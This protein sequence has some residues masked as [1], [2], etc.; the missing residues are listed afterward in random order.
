MSKIGMH[1][2]GWVFFSILKNLFQSAAKHR[3]ILA[4]YFREFCILFRSASFM[5]GIL[6]TA[7]ESR[8]S[9]HLLWTWVYFTRKL[10]NR[11][12]AYFPIID[13]VL[14]GGISIHNNGFK[15]LWLKRSS[16]ITTTWYWYRNT[17][18]LYHRI[19]VY[20]HHFKFVLTIFF[21]LLYLWTLK[22]FHLVSYQPQVSVCDFFICVLAIWSTLAACCGKACFC[23]CS[24]FS[25]LMMSYC[26]IPFNRIFLLSS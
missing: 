4:Y 18:L 10:S 6:M 7:C 21:W 16:I 11:I 25:F 22:L 23:E 17:G 15:Q 26:C 12:R 14:W 24:F 2:N 13:I 1:G 8:F 19:C 20:P 5:H 3:T 9:F